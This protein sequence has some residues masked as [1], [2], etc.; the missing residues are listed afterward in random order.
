M[1]QHGQ[2][3]VPSSTS[4]YKDMHQVFTHL[5]SQ[6]WGLDLSNMTHRTGIER[7]PD[8]G[9]LLRCILFTLAHVRHGQFTSS[10]YSISVTLSY[11]CWSCL[12]MISFFTLPLRLLYRCMG[13]R[14][15]STAQSTVAQDRKA[16]IELADWQKIIYP[17][18]CLADLC[19]DYHIYIILEW[20]Y[21][22]WAGK[23][24][25]DGRS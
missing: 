22:L 7:G 15:C 16:C 25:C 12:S 10:S 9:L 13:T 23:N 21:K 20:Q 24:Q 1:Q 18:I 19:H 3:C 2:T 6:I 14:Y 8:D 4:L 17:Y 11:L 5:A